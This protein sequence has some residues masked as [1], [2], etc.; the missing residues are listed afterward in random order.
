V[1]RSAKFNVQN[2]AA[3][4]SCAL[5][6]SSWQIPPWKDS[7]KSFPKIGIQCKHFAH[8]QCGRTG[9]RNLGRTILSGWVSET[10]IW[11]KHRVWGLHRNSGI[12]LFCGFV[13]YSL[14]DWRLDFEWNW[15]IKCFSQA[16]SS[17]WSFF[18]GRIQPVNF[19]PQAGSSISFN[20]TNL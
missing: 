6:G 12:E 19:T 15:L 2:N 17:L 8:L 18:S 3:L 11:W 5:V 1:F 9:D 16:G 7:E 13:E 4:V 10:Q 14:Q 20:F